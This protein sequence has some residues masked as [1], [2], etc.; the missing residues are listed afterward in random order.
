MRR[1]LVERARRRRRPKHG[2]GHRRVDLPETLPAAAAPAEDLLALDEAL[3]RLEAADPLAARLVRLRF[4]AGLT[5]P[6]A[7]EVLGLSLRQAERNWTYA[8]TWLHREVAAIDCRNPADGR[9]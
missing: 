8:R 1:I 5:M 6:E 3:N 4:F 9:P 2:G 7:A